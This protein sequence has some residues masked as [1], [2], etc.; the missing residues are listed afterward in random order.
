[1]DNI[2]LQVKGMTCRSCVASVTRALQKVPGVTGVDVDLPSGLV[3]VRVDGEVPM[4]PA[5]T[6]A[7]VAALAAAGYSAAP[8][9]QGAVSPAPGSTPSQCGGT[10]KHDQ[11]GQRSRGCCCGH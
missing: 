6:A 2:E 9:R 8:T 4:P 5:V 3:Q 11:A 10:D 7:L 1:M